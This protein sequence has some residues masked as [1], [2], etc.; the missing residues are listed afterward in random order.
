[1]SEEIQELKID[2]PLCKKR[3]SY[4]L[5]VDRTYVMYHMDAGTAQD[6][7]PVYKRFER[8]FTC[9]TKDEHF[10]AVIRLAQEFGTV[11]KGVKVVMD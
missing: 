2:C 4:S 5:A 9:P 7:E 6:D 10:K 11:I 3:H 8:M 1:M